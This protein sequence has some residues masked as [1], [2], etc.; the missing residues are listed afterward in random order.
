M[1]WPLYFRA[2]FYKKSSLV[3]ESHTVSHMSLINKIHD[4]FANGVHSCR[5]S[6]VMGCW[7]S[8]AIRFWR[9]KYSNIYRFYN[10]LPSSSQS[11]RSVSK[12][13]TPGWRPFLCLNIA[14]AMKSGCCFLS[15][16]QAY[17]KKQRMR[18]QGNATLLPSPVSAHGRNNL[19][20]ISGSSGMKYAPSSSNRSKAEVDSLLKTCEG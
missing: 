5:C 19:R 10:P 20:K 6:V 16:L 4:C 17:Q 8:I 15:N 3:R 2:I 14:F 9:G 13:S 1:L 12:S 7:D 11:L 18:G